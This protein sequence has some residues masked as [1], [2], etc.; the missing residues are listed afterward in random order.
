MTSA[1]TSAMK[2]R[3]MARFETPHLPVAVRV[4]GSPRRQPQ[5]LTLVLAIIAI[6]VGGAGVVTTPA[7]ARDFCI[8][9]SEPDAVYSC[10]VETGFT[11]PAEAAAKLHCIKELARR[12]AHRSCSVSRR[13]DDVTCA[14][15]AVV[16][17]PPSAIPAGPGS[18]PATL[19]A[20]MPPN[21]LPS[22]RP[23]EVIGS[24]GEQD[25]R[26]APAQPGPQPDDVRAK[27]DERPSGDNASQQHD[28]TPSQGVE[29]QPEQTVQEEPQ[30]RSNKPPK[31]VEEM[32]KRAAEDS[33]KGLK[34]A[35]ELVT[36][37]AKSTGKTI[38]NTGKAVGNAAKKT[39]DCVSSLF[40]KC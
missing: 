5:L 28:R 19:P 8:S 33:Q 40:S 23:S 10:Q 2:S 6:H 9:C 16:L 31:T 7:S 14:G 36:D 21:A 13:N 32:A 22:G 34:Q 15:E 29:V 17:A 38:E 30:K 1:I 18:A 35:G 39:W 4:L 25:Y 27:I 11:L 37:T 26:Y 3:A 24:Q 12:G 20:A